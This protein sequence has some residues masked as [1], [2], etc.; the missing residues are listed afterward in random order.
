MKNLILSA[1]I[2]VSF[3]ANSQ[4]SQLNH[5]NSVSEELTHERYRTNLSDGTLKGSKSTTIYQIELEKNIH[6][7]VKAFSFVTEGTSNKDVNAGF[8]W[9][10]PNHY[11]HPSVFYSY[12]HKMGYLFLNNIYYG[13]KISDIENPEN[14]KIE[15]IYVP[16]QKAVKSEEGQKLTLKEKM[17]AAKQKLKDEIAASE[18]GL[19]ASI[20]QINHQETI[21]AYLLAMKK[22]QA[23]ATANFSPEIK[24]EI[25][26]IEQNEKDKTQKVKDVNNAYWA[27]EEGQR[28]LAERRK[29]S[30]KTSSYTIVNA[31]NI[32]VRIG[33]NGWTENLNPGDKKTIFCNADVFYM[34]LVGC[35]SWETATLITKGSAACGKTINL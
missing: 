24:E 28:V 14:F 15:V 1:F 17:A 2:L 35:C 32:A 4:E 27:S 18:G 5:L 22:I 19:P 34:K 25:A 26:A 9:L 23:N 7:K 29:N 30:G 16:K 20:N 21:T 8:G 3:I 13:L 6:N 31:K 33:G 12:R 11:T 10:E